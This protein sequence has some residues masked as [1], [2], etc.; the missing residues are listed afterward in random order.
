[1]ESV[2]GNLLSTYAVSKCTNELYAKVFGECFA[3]ETIGLRYFKVLGA[4][5]DPHG[6]YVGVIP[7]V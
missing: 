2:I 7:L 3:M 5:Q 6:M 1:M 4:C